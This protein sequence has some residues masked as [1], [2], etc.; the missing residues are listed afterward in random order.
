MKDF[1]EA[2]RNHGGNKGDR[3]VQ[4]NKVAEVVCIRSN[5]W[6]RQLRDTQHLS[7]NMFVR[8]AERGVTTRPEP[9]SSTSNV[10][11]LGSTIPRCAAGSTPNA[12]ESLRLLGP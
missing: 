7:S 9:T 1:S 5:L 10:K 4:V 2:C 6:E 8:R 11:S 12:E 3:A